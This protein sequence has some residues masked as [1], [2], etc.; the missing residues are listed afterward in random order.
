M[1]TEEATQKRDPYASI[2][3]DKV[4]FKIGEVAD[5]VGVKPYVLRY[6]ET[7]FPDIAPAKSKSK[8]RLYKR[9]EVEAILRIRDL[10]Y[11]EKFTIEGA[12]KRIKELAR[13]P[14]DK[15]NSP[16]ISLGLPIAA[17]NDESLI[18]IRKK[19]EELAKILESL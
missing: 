14:R 16:Q 2:I 17:P 11:K 4:Y 3:P 12:R 5:I 6:W 9:K 15:D 18:E 10:L 13:K 7:E 19:L 1:K 8:Q